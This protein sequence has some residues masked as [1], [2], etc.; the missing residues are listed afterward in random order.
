MKDYGHV[1]VWLDYYNKHL[2]RSRGRRLGRERCVY[3]P[4]IKELAGAAEAAGLEVKET[5]DDV[6]FPRRPHV[7]SGYIVLPKTGPKGRILGKISAR[8]VAR[9]AKQPKKS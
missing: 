9:R 7:Q 4:S 2:A 5:R 3:D 1:V 8:M 6:R